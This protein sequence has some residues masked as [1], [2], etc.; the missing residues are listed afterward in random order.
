MESLAGSIA[1]PSGAA[2]SA[3]RTNLK[4]KFRLGQAKNFRQPNLSKYA[5]D[6]ALRSAAGR[7]NLGINAYGAGVLSSGLDGAFSSRGAGG[8]IG[9]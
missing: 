1:A 5:D 8:S 4:N 6:A 2:A 7:T 3:F 9:K